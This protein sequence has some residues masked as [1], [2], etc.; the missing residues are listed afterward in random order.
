MAIA[1][2]LQAADLKLNWDR[3]VQRLRVEIG[4]DLYNSWFARMEL[5]DFDAGR[6]T[7]SVPTRFLKSWIEAHYVQRL[8]KIAAAEV[9]ELD[10]IF[11]KV[12][13][14]GVPPRPAAAA[15][16]RRPA[17]ALRPVLPFD[18]QA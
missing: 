15:P 17:V 14:S 3:V 4:E 10:G 18:A 7:V 6:L 9:G 2:A 5:E 1:M 12:R 8:H 11:V 16:D 13:M